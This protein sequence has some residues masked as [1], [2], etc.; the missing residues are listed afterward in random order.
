MILDCL[1]PYLTLRV[2]KL[3]YFQTAHYHKSNSVDYDNLKENY[4]ISKYVEALKRNKN[5]S[6]DNI[7]KR[8]VT[9]IV[10]ENEKVKNSVSKRK[11]STPKE[12]KIVSFEPVA[13]R[14]LKPHLVNKV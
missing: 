13:K 3:P 14:F 1:R 4:K 5:R 7:K 10:E 11:L 2:L 12:N 8:S 6:L 9:S